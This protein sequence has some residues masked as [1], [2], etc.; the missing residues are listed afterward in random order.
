MASASSLAHFNPSKSGEKGFETIEIDPQYAQSLGLAQDDIVSFNLQMLSSFMKLYS[1]V[2]IGLIH[3]LSTAKSVETEPLT[4]DDWDIIV[5]S[6]C[7]VCV[8]ILILVSFTI[9]NKCLTCR[10]DPTIA[11]SC[12]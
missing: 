1:Q 4:S 10:V 7:L 2:D 3:D 9:G 6:I 11:G 5:N 8:F 12:C